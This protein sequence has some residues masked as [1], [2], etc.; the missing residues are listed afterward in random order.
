MHILEG[1]LD[2]KCFFISTLVLTVFSALHLPRFSF[3]FYSQCPFLL[4]WVSQSPRTA[5]QQCCG[6]LHSWASQGDPVTFSRTGLP[7]SP[8]AMW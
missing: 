6:G 2:W 5:Q 8:M 1:V 4:A 7:L 3:P